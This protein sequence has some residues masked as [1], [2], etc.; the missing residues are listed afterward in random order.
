MADS[1]RVQCGSPSV[2]WPAWLQRIFALIKASDV[3]KVAKKAFRNLCSS[4]SNTTFPFAAG[5]IFYGLWREGIVFSLQIY[6][7]ET[8]FAD[9]PRVRIAYFVQC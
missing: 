3:R 4:N 8:E 1:L 7:W 9:M 2:V 6:N 5:W